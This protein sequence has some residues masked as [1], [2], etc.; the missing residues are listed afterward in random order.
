[1]ELQG[2]N[3]YRLRQLSRSAELLEM[4]AIYAHAGPMP[5]LHHHPS[6]E[7]RFTVLEGEIAAVIDGVEQ[8]F[9]SSG[10]TFAVPAGISHQMTSRG[11]A[12]MRWEVRPALRTWEFFER[13]YGSPPRDAVEGAALLAEFEPEI[14]FP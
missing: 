8:T 11:P 2:H 6:Q 13:L 5:P 12:R 3:G 10:V 7:E 4:E 14:R 1:M 9:S